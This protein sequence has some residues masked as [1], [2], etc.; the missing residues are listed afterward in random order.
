MDEIAVEYSAEQLDVI[1]TFN[2]SLG[3]QLGHVDEQIFVAQRAGAIRDFLTLSAK[4]A[5]HETYFGWVRDNCDL[6][7]HVG[8]DWL[9][10]RDAFTKIKGGQFERKQTA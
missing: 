3:D 8:F 2:T 9:I 7:P 4:P 6:P 1:R 10:G 5:F